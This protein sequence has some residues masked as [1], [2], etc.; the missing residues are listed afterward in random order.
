M[1]DREETAMMTVSQTIKGIGIRTI[2]QVTLFLGTIYQVTLFLSVSDFT[3][4]MPVW[5]CRDCC[6]LRRSM[7]EGAILSAACFH[8]FRIQ[9][10]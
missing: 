4:R 5:F 8:M 9:S 2:Y 7:P 10:L 3:V 1:E 6:E